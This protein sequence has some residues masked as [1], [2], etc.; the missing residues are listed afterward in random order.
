MIANVK[1][2]SIRFEHFEKVLKLD[3]DKY[4][5]L[6][7]KIIPEY[8]YLSEKRNSTDKKEYTISG[9]YGKIYSKEHLKILCDLENSI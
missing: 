7:S 4:D 3:L 2:C 6:K 8:Y 5:L 9:S 1:V